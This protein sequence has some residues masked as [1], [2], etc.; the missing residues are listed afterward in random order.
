MQADADAGRNYIV[1]SADAHAAPDDM[2]LMLSYVDPEHRKLVEMFGNL[3]STAM[4]MLG[5]ENV[6]AIEDPDP[7]RATAATRLSGMGV[8]VEAASEWLSRYSE[9]W[10]I[11]GDGDGKRLQVLEEQG[12]HGEVTYPGPILSG[13]ISPAMYMGSA[14]DQNLD[15]VWPAIHGYNRWLKDFC[16]AVPGRRAGV[17]PVDLHDIE[18][19]AREVTWCRDNGIFGGVMLPGM[20]IRSKLPGYAD[21]Y[22][23]P[24]WAACEEHGF[25]INLHTGA[26]GIATDSKY[27]YDDAHGGLLGLYEAFVFSRRP[28][29]F[30]LFGGVFDRFPGLKVVVAENG[31]QWLP[32]FVRDM[33]QF[34]D[35]H[36][37]APVRRHLRLRPAE[38]IERHVYLAGSL[39]KRY[40]AEMSAEIGDGKLM[41]GA[42]YPHL[43]GA[44]PVHREVMRHVFGGLSEVDVRAMLGGNAM[45]LWDFDAVAL[46]EAADRCGP[47]VA[48]VAAPLDLR[49]FPETFSWSLARPVP[50]TA[51]D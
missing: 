43:E 33:E 24:F 9:D 7:V 10:V 50:I 40:E 20:S 30:M 48:E 6:V 46:R 28:L 49:D 45:E 15:A 23:D 35:T 5:G 26:S 38:Y 25:V 31:V 8:D 22:Y 17:I 19:A 39:M 51:A 2:D 3:S 4:T 32:S 18:R 36:G 44:V 11:A 1:V 14:T 16:A 42:D 34:F 37:G 21:P 29:W 27:L 12:I 13:A 47:T 41:W